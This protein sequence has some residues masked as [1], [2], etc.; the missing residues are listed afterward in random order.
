MGLDR[1]WPIELLPFVNEDNP[2]TKIT[3]YSA[4][5]VYQEVTPFFGE[6]ISI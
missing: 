2:L 1:M 3:H 6:G 5:K 4:K